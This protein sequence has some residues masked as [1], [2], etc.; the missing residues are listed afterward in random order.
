MSHIVIVFRTDG[1]RGR[2][3]Y[4]FFQNIATYVTAMYGT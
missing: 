4:T 3:E 2:P 1:E